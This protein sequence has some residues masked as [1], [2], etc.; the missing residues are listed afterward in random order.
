MMGRQQVQVRST[1][2]YV[3]ST[4]PLSKEFRARLED[5]IQVSPLYLSIAELRQR[6]AWKAL[7]M[8]LS[9]RVDILF[10][11][12]EDASGSAA[13]PILQL[14]SGVTRARSVRLINPQRTQ[15]SVSTGQVLK[16]F[17]GFAW[18]SL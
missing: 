11:A 1:N 7:N 3:L 12:T 17:S 16:S 9:L 2:S 8:L 5:G 10:L 18:A 13:L 15:S 6:S 4:Y 14:L